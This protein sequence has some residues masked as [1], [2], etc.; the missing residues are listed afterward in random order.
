[1]ESERQSCIQAEYNNYP[2]VMW[3]MQPQIFIN[4]TAHPLCKS[5]ED[6]LFMM[7]DERRCTKDENCVLVKMMVEWQSG[8]S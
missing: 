2:R 7:K 5:D 6:G 4:Q 1:M 8:A 3:T